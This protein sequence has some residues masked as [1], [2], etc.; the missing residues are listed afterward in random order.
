MN[1]AP[2]II[3]AVSCLILAPASLAQDTMPDEVPLQPDPSPNA[4]P[5]T[6]R[7]R[8][9]L[10]AGPG[11]EASR[12]DRSIVRYGLDGRIVPLE[13]SPEESALALLDLE[14]SDRAKVDD[15][16]AQRAA[17][18]DGVVRRNIAALLEARAA[19]DG[20]DPA[21]AREVLDRL[22]P[23]L[24]PLQARGRAREEIAAA[25]PAEH[26]KRFNAL[27]MEYWTSVLRQ[28]REDASN[29]GVPFD[30]RAFM[31]D[32]L[33]EGIGRELR[34]S[35][36]RIVGQRVAELDALLRELALPSDKEDRIRTIATDFA[37]D[38]LLNPTDAERA[39]LFRRI[40]SELDA[41]E[42]QRLI[43]ILRRER[44]A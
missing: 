12:G 24:Q 34:S 37:A 35:Y 38:T 42:R 15:L 18:L 6:P 5:P 44:G 28:A 8:P 41:S 11:D 17:I 4:E 23:E 7:G 10:L 26:A 32:V 2:K 3:A 40:F 36:E 1:H 33:R 19:R 9:G 20:G 16:L 13:S 22:L 27:L 43:E 29:S 31:R 14:P 39:E 25:L 30:Q 21:A